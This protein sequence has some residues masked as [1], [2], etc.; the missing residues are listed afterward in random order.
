MYIWDLDF[1]QASTAMFAQN[2]LVCLSC[3]STLKAWLFAN[4]DA[5]TAVVLARSLPFDRRHSSVY[6]DLPCFETR[7]PDQLCWGVQG[8]DLANCKGLEAE[9]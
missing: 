6:H 3:H 8:L 2:L 5:H 9:V 4:R 7:S 1:S